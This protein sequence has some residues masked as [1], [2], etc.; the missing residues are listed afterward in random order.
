METHRFDLAF[1][2]KLS[3]SALLVV[4]YGSIKLELYSATKSKAS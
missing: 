1:N 3:L 4:G 2:N